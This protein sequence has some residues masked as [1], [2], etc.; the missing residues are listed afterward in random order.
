LQQLMQELAAGGST[1]RF[2]QE[3]EQEGTPM[4]EPVDADTS[5]PSCAGREKRLPAGI[6]AGDH[7]PLFRLGHSDV[8]FRSYV[9]PADT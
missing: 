7:D 8:W 9:V 5:A 4:V 3:R 6:P 2:W 1:T